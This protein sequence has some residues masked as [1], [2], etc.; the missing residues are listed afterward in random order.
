MFIKGKAGLVCIDALQPFS[1][2]WASSIQPRVR[3]RLL[4]LGRLHVDDLI[5]IRLE[6]GGFSGIRTE[7]RRFVLLGGTRLFCLHVLWDSFAVEGFK[8]TFS[9][10]KSSNNKLPPRGRRAGISEHDAFTLFHCLVVLFTKNHSIIYKK[11]KGAV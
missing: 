10:L 5:E 4:A 7:V 8:E 11:Y 3:P 1:A 2:L 6:E 9:S